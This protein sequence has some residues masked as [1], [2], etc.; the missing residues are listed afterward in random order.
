MK[1]YQKLLLGFCLGVVVG[2][3]A[4]YLLPVKEYP[5][6]K[7]F[8]EVCAF[9][10]AVF[11]RTIFMIVIPLLLSALMLGVYEL[12]QGRGLGK[13]ASHS[14]GYTLALSFCAVMISI[15][16]TNFIQPGKGMQFD[17][18]SLAQNASVINIKA[19]VAA[20]ADKVWYQ[21]IV[22]LIPQN[23]VD[24]MARAFS[25]EIIA[26]MV[27]ALVF[28]Y[29][30]SL[31]VKD[32]NNP[33]VNAL[34]TVFDVSVQ[35][36]DFAM[37][38]APYGIFGIVFNTAYRLGAGFLQNVAL[39]AFVVIAGLLI[40]LLVV[41]SIF[42]STFG[43]TSPWKFFRDCREVY[44]YAFSTASSNATLPIALEAAERVLKIP[45]KIARFV[46]T[47]GASA[48]QNGSALFE[49]VTVL[50]L[51]Q[52]YGID[53]SFGSQMLVVMMAMMAS[54]GTAGVPGGAL[55]LV[56]IVMMQVGI[57]AEGIGIILGV[58][59]LLDMCRTTL[60]VAGD[61]VIAKL[62]SVTSGATADTAPQAA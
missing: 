25:G 57:P 4:Y 12:A 47:I 60:N 19:N 41:Y 55:P 29:A 34:R 35:V 61:L 45:P 39:Y 8:T 15:L 46:L 49:G 58:D 18:V 17:K 23:P 59:R 14:I 56:V 11:L 54:I 32:E 21:Y 10:G 50:F 42:L 28:G 31:V 26:V 24:S 7:Q 13:I 37:I 36:V 62:V 16:M 1:Q 9:A 44:V 40:Q 5:F 51:A 22:D 20:A 53:L 2:L 48:N 6:M 38:V 33:L 27:F 43:R 52:V 30:L 3:I